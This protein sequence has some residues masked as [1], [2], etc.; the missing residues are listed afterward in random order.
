[1]L[2]LSL[3]SLIPSAAPPVL[4]LL[5]K[6]GCR[7]ARTL[8]GRVWEGGALEAGGCQHGRGAHPVRLQRRDETLCVGMAE[9]SE[10]RLW[11]F[12]LMAGRLESSGEDCPLGTIPEEGTS[13]CSMAA[14]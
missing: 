14:L 10:T 8:P 1:M 7:T 4:A 6:K 3:L 9:A 12:G 2:V 11:R 5:P 13:S